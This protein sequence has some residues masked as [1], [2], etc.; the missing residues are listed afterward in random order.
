VNL[1]I[2]NSALANVLC[3]DTHEMLAVHLSGDVDLK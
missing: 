3:E 2:K 1:P